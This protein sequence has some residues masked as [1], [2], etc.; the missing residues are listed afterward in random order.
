MFQPDKDLS[1]G[2]AAAV[3]PRLWEFA[4]AIRRGCKLF[5]K[6]CRGA[7]YRGIDAACA[8]GAARAVGFDENRH[9]HATAILGC[10]IE[11][12]G[13]DWFV[14]DMVTHLNDSHHWTRE[15]IADWLETL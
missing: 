13:T 15:R 11:T 1:V 5:P 9:E 7:L 12:C 4:D 10:P 8:L 2:E 14:H 3:R 6:Q